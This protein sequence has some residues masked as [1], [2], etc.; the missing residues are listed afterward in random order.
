MPVGPSPRGL[1][2]SLLA[3]LA[4]LSHDMQAVRV[5]NRFVRHYE[6]LSYDPVAVHNV[7]RWKRS[8]SAH[9]HDSSRPRTVQVAFKAH[10]REFRLQLTQDRSAFSDD[11]SLVTSRGRVQASL[12]HIYSG[13]VAGAPG[14]RVVGAMMDGV[15]SG[16]I[17]LTP[18]DDDGDFYV[19]RAGP[20]LSSS[21]PTAL[22]HSLIYAA[23]DVS[24]DGAGCGIHLANGSA[25]GYAPSD[26]SES[27]RINPSD[28][29][30]K[31]RPAVTG[32]W[33][34]R[35]G[36]QRVCNLEIKVDHTFY[37]MVSSDLNGD[38]AKV[39]ASITELVFTHVASASD[40]FG[41]T[42][43]NGITD[44]SFVV[45]RLQI[46]DSSHCEGSKQ[47]T[48]PYCSDTLDATLT[49]IELSK[50]N[51]DS[52]C[53]SYLWTYRDYP[54]GTLG[55]AYVAELNGIPGN[56]GGLCE[57]FQSDVALQLTSDYTGRV[58]LNTGV[59][60]FV[61]KNVRVP[62][63]VSEVTF[64]HELGHSFGAQHDPP[65]CVPGGS[66]GNFLMF[67]SASHGTMPNNRRFSMCSIRDMSAVLMQMFSGQGSRSNCLQ[68]LRGPF[69]GN[70]IREDDEECDCGLDW[71]ECRELCCYPRE[72]GQLNRKGCTLRPDAKC[73]PSNSACCSDNCQYYNA[74][75]VCRHDDDCRF[76]AYCDGSGGKC[77]P[78]EHKRDGVLCNHR[79]Q[80]CQ[81]GECTGSLC[82]LY[83]LEECYL[84]GPHRT[85]DEMCLIACRENVS[86]SV[87]M[88]ACRFDR[89]KD[90]CNKKLEPGAPCDDLRGYCDIFQRCR[91][92][93]AEGPLARLHWLVFGGHGLQNLLVRFRRQVSAF[94]AQARR[95]ALQPPQPGVPERRV[96]GLPVPT[97]RPRG[98]LP[99]WAPPHAGRDVPHC[100]PRECVRQRVHGGVPLRPHEG[101][102]QQEKLEPGA[103]CDDLRGY[104]DIF[105]RCR[106]VDAE[107]PL[108]RLHWLVFGG[109]GLQNL[110]VRF[111]RQVSAFGAQA[112]RRALQPPQPG[113]PERR[114]HGLPVPTVRPRGVLPH[115]APPH[116]GRDVPHCVPRECVRQRVHGGVPLRP[117]EGLLQQEKLEP[118]APCDDLRGYCDIFQR[119][120]LVDAEGPLARLHWLVFGGHGL[121][122]L[123]VRYW[124]LTMLGVMASAG[125]TV[126][127]IKLCAVH[128]PSSNPNLKRPRKITETVLRPMSL[129]RA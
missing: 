17:S 48:N 47:R 79:S 38:A 22:F 54:K 20:Y 12:D 19:E 65:E 103:P 30:R 98:V 84:T 46:N 81:N 50:S 105:Q 29:A 112:R 80:V 41:R 125:A 82:R 113:V 7:G 14:S 16:R 45:Q 83:D 97:V 21:S 67:A 88:E 110:L 26:T 100:V 13:H 51:H 75:W 107:G 121:Q 11:F 57:K 5:L 37:E 101:L 66:A 28:G 3:A 62:H 109:H 99:H 63:R 15:F 8:A 68:E 40:I 93:D 116:A 114:V 91:L 58:S 73:S 18:G 120:R 36:V 96:H 53:L 78:S 6:P 129:L 56:A 10:G 61:N 43:F 44:I 4:L 94:G 104:C 108:A 31:P 117:H 32:Y 9:R 72:H 92:V 69:C 76:E 24:F 2:A 55:L 35:S 74:T 59:V 123:L 89:M 90:F 34:Q 85:P 127:F 27:R 49:L 119:C 106:L 25:R 111:R 102:L 77:P 126:L 122:N 33:R 64:A 52:Y 70:S 39:R 60:T 1:A 128:T 95:R 42:N 124:Y 23:K 86:G 115:W 71:S 87:C 118:G